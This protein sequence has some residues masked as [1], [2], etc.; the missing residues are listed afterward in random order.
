MKNTNYKKIIISLIIILSL[1]LPVLATNTIKAQAASK[2]TVR[3]ATEKQLKSALKNSKVGTIILRTQTYNAITINSK[4]A[5]KKNIIIDAPNAVVTNKSK[6]KSIELQNA[7]KYIE[8]VS[9]NTITTTAAYLLEVAEGC[10]VKKLTMP[11][12]M[13]E[14]IIRKG[15]SIKSIVL[16]NLMHI[17]SFDK[18]TGTLAFETT[19]IWTSYDDDLYYDDGGDDVISVEYIDSYTAILDKC[20][21]TLSYNHMGW[22]FDYSYEYKYDED[23]NCLECK[24]T[25][26]ENGLLET[27][28]Y[29]DYD[30]SNNKV[31]ENYEHSYHPYDY[32][33]KYIYDKKGRLSNEISSSD[34]YSEETEFNYDKKGRVIGEKTNKFWYEADGRLSSRKSWVTENEYDKNGNL[35]KSSIE[36]DEGFSYNYTYEYDKDGNLVYYKYILD[37]KGMESSFEYKYEYDEYGKQKEGFYKYEDEWYSMVDYAG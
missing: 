27:T 19:G 31:S 33:V 4:K 12:L 37:D 3:V 36:Y 34:N 13:P 10:S 22:Q 21:R 18:K 7:A 35:I 32:G 26:E 15:A 24:T 14:Y 20:G 9:G 16:K 17:S 28:I 11:Y 30:D 1:V 25:N 8:A 2:K 5:K 23:G 6:F 29:Y